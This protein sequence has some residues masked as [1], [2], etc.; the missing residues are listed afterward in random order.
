MNL[1][2]E[3]AGV[4][5]AVAT[6]GGVSVLFALLFSL[7]GC[8]STPGKVLTS[9]N[10]FHYVRTVYGGKCV[11][12]PNA[13]APP[14]CKEAYAA[15]AAQQ[16]WIFESNDAVKRGGRLPLQLKALDIAEKNALQA[17]EGIKP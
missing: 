12:V 9:V 6:A 14:G 11:T 15:M 10:T 8:Q 17:L 16:Q 5:R 1:S 2:A 3:R 13:V 4:M 7:A